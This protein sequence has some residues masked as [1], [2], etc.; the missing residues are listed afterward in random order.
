MIIGVTGARNSGNSEVA[1]YISKNMI[2]NML[3]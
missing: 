3:M 1:K 2:L